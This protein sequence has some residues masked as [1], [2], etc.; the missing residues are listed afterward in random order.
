MSAWQLGYETIFWQSKPASPFQ[1]E[2]YQGA[3]RV[4]EGEGMP[5][6]PRPS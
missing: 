2:G 5:H 4:R 6:L 3:V 1:K